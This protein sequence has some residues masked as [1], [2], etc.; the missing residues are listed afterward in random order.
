MPDKKPGFMM[1]AF[2]LF[3]L[4]FATGFFIALVSIGKSGVLFKFALS[5]EATKALLYVAAWAPAILLVASAL[6]MESSEARDGF[7]GAAYRIMLPALSLAAIVS[8]FYILIVPGLEERKN[9]YESQSQLFTDSL[10]LAAEALKDNRLDEAEKYLLDCA[11]IDIRDESYIALNDRIKSAGIK[12]SALENAARPQAQSALAVDEVAWKAGIRFYLEALEARTEGNFFDAHYL[13]KRS[14]AVYSKRPEVRRLVEET[15]RDLQR[16]GPTAESKAAAAYY[17]RKLE[18]YERF[19]ESDFLQAFR[20]FTELQA[21]DANDED[22]AVYLERSAEGLSS[23]AFFI[24]EDSKAFSSSDERAF[25]FTVSESG[26]W[27]ATLA[28]ERAAASQDAVY[29][30]GLTL[31]ISGTSPVHVKAPFA[32]LHGTTLILRAV[33]RLDPGTVWEPAYES[34][35]KLQARAGRGTMDPGFAI[36]V[37]FTQNDAVAALRL[38]GAPEDIPIALL[39]TG[40]DDAQRLGIETSPLLAELARRSGYP[41]AVLMLVLIGAGLGVRFKPTEPVSVAMKYLTAPLLVGLARAHLRLDASV[42]V[43]AGMAFAHWIP[44]GL[45]LPAWLGFLG[46]CVVISLFVAA[47][48]AGRSGD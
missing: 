25:T 44:N 43:S 28:A 14:A 2:A 32:R 3:A 33:D 9:R 38:S 22:V 27:A 23:I 12:A 31:D 36:M 45:F 30:R 26:V 47:R 24:E 15:W 29:F 42:A 16:L 7:S 46:V 20:I 13:A 4:A 8:I 34:G 35:Q 39:A 18:G 19:Q 40:I 48:I 41:F 37:P 11:A 21:L 6:A 10:K 1:V 5:W 17:E